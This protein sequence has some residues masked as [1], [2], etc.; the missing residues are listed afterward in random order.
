MNRN[1]MRKTLL[2]ILIS[3]IC[4]LPR[5][6]QAADAFISDVTVTRPPINV[7]FQVKGAFSKDIEEAVKSGLPTSFNFLI[8]LEKVNSIFPNDRVGRWEFRHTVRYDSLRDEY[9]IAL[10]ETGERVRTRD[11]SEM[12]T[13]MASCAGVPV[14]PAHLVPGQPYV[15]RIK[16]ELDTIELPFFLNYMLFF[17]KFLDFETGWHVHAFTP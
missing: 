14:A 10:D 7:S 11:L 6:A 2:I 3:A 17:L 12:K 1:P 15:I 8:E 5:L 16:A 13:L 4:L 9:E